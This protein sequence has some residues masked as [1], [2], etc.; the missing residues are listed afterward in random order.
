MI[1]GERRR[2]VLKVIVEDYITGAIPVASRAIV[3]K[4]GL[5]VSTATIRN[6]MACLEQEGYIIHPYHSAGSV[7]TDKA[8]RYYVE[9]MAES[10]ELA[11]GEQD[12][13][14]QLLQ[15]TKE[16]LERW[17]KLVAALLARFVDNMTVITSPKVMNCRLRHLD[18][19]SLQD[20]MVLMVSVLYGA[21]VRRRVLSFEKKVSQDELTKIANKLT[22][23]FAG[24]TRN[25][26]L[27]RKEG[28]SFEEKHVAENL[29][30][31]IAVENGLEYGETYFEGLRLMLGQ[32][33]FAAG[34]E[35]LNIL[36]VLEGEDWLRCISCRELDKGKVKV[37]IGEENPEPALQDLS[38]IV[39]RYGMIGR[40]SGIVG[41]IG[42]KRMDYAK[43]ISSLNCLSV[44]LS[45][46]VAE[47]V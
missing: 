26:I 7:P 25:E 47:Y 5:K 21:K 24:R 41:V 18:L 12:F 46:S 36:E 44:L 6:D 34:S 42:P 22:I 38:L 2:T 39:S 1:L 40:A 4:R 33:E 29:A 30:E 35:I 8:Y 28:L 9:S 37:I 15:E 16:E 19:V 43:T 23:D 10:V 3:D 14:N 32:P 31:I 27:A 11:L 20:F 13:I 17:L 45:N